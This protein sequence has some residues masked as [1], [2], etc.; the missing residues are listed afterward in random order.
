MPRQSSKPDHELISQDEFRGLYARGISDTCPPNFFLDC[1]NVKFAES[2]VLSRDGLVLNFSLSSIV[3]KFVYKRLNETPRFI[4]LTSDGKLWDSLYGSPIY[5]DAAFTDFSMI[6]YN[7]RAYITPH[8]RQYGITG[9][10]VLVYDGSGTAR[11]AGGSAPTGFTLG[12]VES[13]TS[14]NCEAGIHLI[15]LAGLTQSGFITVPGPTIF[16]QVTSTG[17]FKIDVSAI[18]NL[19]S[20]YVG[21]V[22]LATKAIPTTLFNGNQFGYEFFF[23]PGALVLTGTTTAS[24]SFYDADLANS[25]DYLFDNLSSIPAGVGIASYNGRIIVWGEQASQHTVRMSNQGDPEV[26]DGT[27]GFLTVDPSEAVSGIRNC[28]EFRKSLIICKS[29]RIYGTT[30]N[31]DSPNTWAVDMVDKSVGTECFGVATVL[32]A[33]GVNNDRTFI[34]TLSG[35]VSY[36]GLIK[37]PEL[38][39]NIEDVWKRINK[40]YFNLVQVVDDPVNHRVLISVPLDNATAISH[41]LFGDYSKAYTVYGNLDETQIKWCPWT[42]PTAPV[43][44]TGDNDSV[45]FAPVIHI[46]LAGGNVYDMKAGLTSDFNNAITAYFKTALK[47]LLPGWQHHF[48]GIKLRCTGSGVLSIDLYGEDNVTHQSVTGITL[49]AS[50]GYEPDRLINFQNEK[51]SIKFG[52]TLINQYFVV[53]RVDTYAKPTWLRRPN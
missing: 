22:I 33:R 7:N 53:T 3:R 36:E 51:M 48:G 45:T 28:F 18:P 31:N 10:S 12:A 29:N 20:N 49:A 35:L 39:W 42:F 21:C 50:P 24:I 8:N 4:I 46:A 37:R 34:A 25:A 13:S 11:L 47:A 2:D 43:S 9:K 16:A 14:G 44:I 40:A 17:G 6:N 26:F 27:S 32:D 5:S 23:V 38:T 19:G 1:L 30:D 52:I 41:I 15:A